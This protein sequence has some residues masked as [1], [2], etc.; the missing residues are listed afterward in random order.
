MH[1][2]FRPIKRTLVLQMT[3]IE[4][5]SN[6]LPPTEQQTKAEATFDAP[7][8]NSVLL[9]EHNA[10]ISCLTLDRSKNRLVVGSTDYSVSFWDL[11]N[12]NKGLKPFRVLNPHDQQIVRAVS[13][14]SDSQQLLVCGGGAKPKIMSRDGR[15]IIEFMKGD[16]YLRDLTYTKGHTCGVTDGF[17]SPTSV[18]KCYTASLDGTIRIWDVNAQPFGIEQQLPCKS[19]IKLKGANMQRVGVTKCCLIGASSIAGFC[20]DG[21]IQIWAENAK[22]LRPEALL[23]SPKLAQACAVNLL[24]DGYTM[25]TRELDDTLKT[26]DLR[27]FTDIVKTFVNLPCSFENMSIAISPNE[28]YVV[29][30]TTVSRTAESQIVFQE[31]TG[32]FKEERIPVGDR[33]VT[34]LL[35]DTELNQIFAGIGHD[36]TVFFNP[37]KSKRGVI[38]AVD[39]E[40]RKHTIEDEFGQKQIYVPNALSM[41][42]PDQN[43]KRKRFEKIRTDEKLTKKPTEM[44]T[45][46]GY[47]GMIAGPRTTA[48]FVMRTIH[49]VR[50]TKIDPLEALKQRINSNKSAPEFVDSAYLLTQPKRILNYDQRDGDQQRLMSLFDKCKHCGMKIC[51]CPKKSA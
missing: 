18:E 1:F 48:Q 13:F 21:S 2:A 26:Y 20:D 11:P 41:F 34:S 28:K 14:S 50:G 23:R 31:L 44:L 8:S 37:E 4:G 43:N 38:G 46:P 6:N 3:E 32:E 25:L 24:N 33:S 12:L 10:L 49:E 19:V 9:K 27:K 29:C 40:T 51:Q 5:A 17:F 45:G 39:K 30:G 47:N 16:M 15:E 35:W 42:R 36:V 22:A 7:M